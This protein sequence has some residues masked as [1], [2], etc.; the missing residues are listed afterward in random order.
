[1]N[2]ILKLAIEKGGYPKDKY[3]NKVSGDF[4]VWNE[5]AVML[6]PEFWKCLGKALDWKDY[7]YSYYNVG[8]AFGLSSEAGYW[9][10]VENFEDIPKQL[11][12][13]SKNNWRKHQIDN[14][15]YKIYAHQYF[16]LI[17]TGGNLEQF[18]EGLLK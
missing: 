12:E 13:G 10:K 7:F 16:D 6:D 1:M 5:S 4:D 15:D 11:R 17:L 14:P 18:W 8:G 3:H 9:K 2:E